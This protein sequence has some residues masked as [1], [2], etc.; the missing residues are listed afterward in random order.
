MAWK[1]RHAEPTR[2]R[3][4]MV[5]ATG[6]LVFAVQMVNFPVAAGVSSHLIGAA[7]AVALIGPL[8]AMGVMTAVIAVQ[9][10]VFADGGIASLGVNTLTM[11]VVAVAAAWGVL[12]LTERWGES[13]APHAARVALAAVASPLAAVTVLTGLYAVAGAPGGPGA[14]EFAG[15]MLTS[16]LVAAVAEGVITAAIVALVAL[17]AAPTRARWI[18][19]SAVIT[20]GGLSM[21]AS[22][23][24]DALESVLA[25]F[26]ESAAAPLLGMFAGYGEGVGVALAGIT[27]IAIVALVL[28]GV[29]AGQRRLNGVAAA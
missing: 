1:A 5:A 19:G 28:G 22:A 17:A 11:A 25:G 14:A 8:A 13:G 20:A 2:D 26:G 15:T 27:G 23:Y 29:G 16:H 7:L 4:G 9:A 21:V 10:F 3:I 12:K 24:P 18:A 6:A